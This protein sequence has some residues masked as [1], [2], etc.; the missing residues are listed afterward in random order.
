ML[1]AANG[2]FCLLLITFANSLDPD[3]DQQSVGPD[4]YHSDSD[5]E[6]IFK[7][8]KIAADDKILHQ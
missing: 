6:R 7:K 5:S 2:H 4:F 8:M 1:P 3:Q